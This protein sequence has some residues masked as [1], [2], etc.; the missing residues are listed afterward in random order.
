V[1]TRMFDQRSAAPT[2][3]HQRV[4]AILA[5]HGDV[6]LRIARQ[7]ALCADDAHD[8]VQRALEIYMRRVDSLDPATELA[9]MKVVVKHESLAVRR[10]RAAV[11]SEDVDL[12][13]VPAD[14]QRSVEERF[15]SNERVERSAEVM[16]RLKRDEARALL[17]KAE[18]LSYKEIGERLGWTY[19]KV[20][21]A[22]TEGRR[23][24][25]H[26]YEELE[27]GVE[28]ERLA[29]TLEALAQGKASSE[30]M[31]ELRPHLRNCAGCRATVRALHT[32]HLGRLSAFATALIAPARAIVERLKASGA[33]GPSDA[34]G[35][36][37][38]MDRQA[39]VDELF[40][41]LNGGESAVQPVAPSVAESVGRVSTVRV[42]VRDWA[43]AAL[44]R[45]QSSDLA[46][47]IHAASTGGGGRIS[48]IAA[49]IGICVSGVGAGTY[50][51]ATSLLPD[52][53]PAITR[54]VKPT[55]RKATHASTR[56]SMPSASASLPAQ[57]ARFASAR[58]TLT[59][60]ATPSA[61][62]TA[63]VRKPTPAGEFSFETNSATASTRSPASR[64]S[65]ST[66]TSPASGSFESG[67]AT[68]TTSGHS[69]FSDSAGGEFS[70]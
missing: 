61:R 32:T 63:K 52:P 70:P 36:L 64:A 20:N 35:E 1:A 33:K 8:A 42:N 18:G 53:K 65:T 51:V 66:L 55:K 34:P 16:R 21:R 12:D 10:S 54:D 39:D 22:I 44:H 41:R 25:L 46:M 56:G 57:R 67:N 50:C 11:A 7:Y 4:A 13:A 37:H 31:L 30:A 59:P 49:L 27:T 5:R 17:L 60:T 69:E 48:S 62:T 23:R 45:L 6:L 26:L 15:E 38:P 68:P 43:E 58:P 2:D 14:A 9:W 28:C 24:F 19:T 40:R 3:P 47:G 29:P